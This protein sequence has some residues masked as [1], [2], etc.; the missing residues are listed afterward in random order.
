M[1]TGRLPDP[2]PP[3][4]RIRRTVYASADLVSAPY[5]E[6]AVH[7]DASISSVSIENDPS[8]SIA[9]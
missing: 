6:R 8:D 2:G 1:V 3:A 7:A 4:S 5:G 9:K